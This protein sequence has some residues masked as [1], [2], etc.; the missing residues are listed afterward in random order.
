VHEP[1]LAD[2]DADM[3]GAAA[4]A[5]GVE[6]DQIS[7]LE[8]GRFH[9]VADFELLFDHAR[10]GDAVLR[11]DVLHQAA[12]IEAPGICSS[13]AV[14]YAAESHRELRDG[15]AVKAPRKKVGLLAPLYRVGL[16]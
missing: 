5:R 4:P 3:R 14:G 10:N 7:G 9:P 12:A 8:V 11:E 6:E 1:V 16:A 13:R 15:P 2:R